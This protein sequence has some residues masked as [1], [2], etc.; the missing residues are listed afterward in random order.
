MV[1]TQPTALG[2]TRSLIKTILKV[3]EDVPELINFEKQQHTNQ[4]VSTFDLIAINS[5]KHG[6]E[7][8]TTGCLF[9]VLFQ[10]A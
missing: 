3:S 1:T 9:I 2:A 10:S 5:I 8:F 6:I 4:T 7:K